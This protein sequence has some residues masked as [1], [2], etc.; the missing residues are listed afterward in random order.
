MALITYGAGPVIVTWPVLGKTHG[1]VL[2]M[3]SVKAW[4][5]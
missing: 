3:A 2:D 4:P 5:G 1:Q